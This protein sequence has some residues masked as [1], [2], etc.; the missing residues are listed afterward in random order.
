VGLIIASDSLRP[1]KWLRL[2]TG[3]YRPK[4]CHAAKAIWWGDSLWCIQQTSNPLQHFVRLS[5]YVAKYPGKIDLYKLRYEADRRYHRDAA[6]EK[7]KDLCLRPYGWRN[8]V[9]LIPY[10]L[11]LIRRLLPGDTQETGDTWPL[12]CSGT[13]SRSDRAGGVD[14][15]PDLAD[16]ATEPESLAASPCYKYVCTL[17]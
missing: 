10:H 1:S 11:P 17:T 15:R 2:L 13:C 5:G 6:V 14:P 7:H 16:W 9:K 4:H 3:R 12:D 8:I